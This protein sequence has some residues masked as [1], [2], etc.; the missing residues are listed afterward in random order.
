MG[1]AFTDALHADRD[2]EHLPDVAPPI[3]VSTTFDRSRQGA[4][5]YRRDQHPTR[6][7]LEAVIGA[8]EGG[9]AVI[10]PSGMAAITTILL[11]LKPR[12]IYLPDDCYHGA[13]AMITA[14]AG[15]GRWTLPDDPAML[16]AG[17][18]WWVETPSN[19]KCLITDIRS[20]TAEAASRGVATLV[21]STFATPILQQP[22]RL[23]AD[24]VMHATTKF[25]G[26]HSDSMGGV[27]VTADETLAQQ[28]R[29]ERNLYGYV[30]GPLDVWLALRGVRTLPLRIERQTKTAGAIAEFL[31][32]Q[33]ETVWYP[34][35]SS[36]P[37]HD[38]AATQMN[39]FGSMVSFELADEETASRVIEKLSL[40]HTA[41]SLGGV[42]SL[43]EHR[44]RVNSAAPPGL[45][46]VSVGLESP[47]DL[48]E[49]LATALAAAS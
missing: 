48:I 2:I 6:E 43:A 10:Y 14:E 12:Q 20:V 46:R 26:G 25:I 28:L 37:G 1:D 3:R 9:H 35:L 22:L 34:G 47:A 29:T 32:D 5:V 23:G 38:V 31:A 39:G 11:H 4:L 49:D 21:D 16:D 42:E 40:I 15:S 45:I 44:Y 8:L 30:P 36:H 7:R 13:R 17:D 33:L 19:P 24:F 18:V 27:I 41:T